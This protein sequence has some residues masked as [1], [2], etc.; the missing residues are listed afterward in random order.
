[1]EVVY[2]NSNELDKVRIYKDSSDYSDDALQDDREKDE[3]NLF[4]NPNYYVINK[5]YWSISG[6]S[7]NKTSGPYNNYDDCYKE[8]TDFIYE[9]E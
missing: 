6:S 7:G 9:Q 8:L 2:D 3:C 1:M 5:Y 4:E